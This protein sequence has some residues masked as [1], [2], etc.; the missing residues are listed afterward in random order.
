MMTAAAFYSVADDG[1]LVYA[2]GTATGRPLGLTWVERDGTRRAIDLPPGEYAHPRFSA[3][4]RWV[5]VEC[6]DGASTDICLWETSGTAAMRRLTDGGNNRYPVWSRDNAY[7]AFQS[8]RTGDR[9]VFLQRVDGGSVEQLTMPPAGTEHIPEDWSPTEDRLAFS[10][11]SGE[12]A[13]LW[14]WTP[15]ARTPQRFG[16]LQ[17]STAFNA[18][19]SPD[20]KWIAYTERAGSPSIYVHSMSMEGRF[21]IGR[22]DDQAH[23]PLWT[24]DGRLIYF[25]GGS[26]RWLSK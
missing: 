12:A 9:G 26:P 25:A 6:K 14:M 8:D 2:S 3:D 10:V 11:V 5:A 15:A 21:P 7:I 13:E 24:P 1:T 4:G 23:H 22:A 17:S 20:G 19:F 16:T 18:V